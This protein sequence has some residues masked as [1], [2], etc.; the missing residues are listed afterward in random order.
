MEWMMGFG[1][2]WVTR[3]DGLSRAAQLRLLGNSV[4]ALQ[5]A[6]ALDVL[7]PAGIPA[8]QLKP[9]TNEPLDAER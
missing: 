5:A 3:I 2:G 8:H 9:G 6:H 1:D 7:L 4:V